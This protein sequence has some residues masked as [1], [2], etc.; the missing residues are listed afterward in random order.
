MSNA[1]FLIRE[2]ILEDMNEEVEQRCYAIT[3]NEKLGLTVNPHPIN[4]EDIVDCSGEVEDDF[5]SSLDDHQRLNS[6]LEHQGKVCRV[7]MEQETRKSFQQIIKEQIKL[8]SVSGP[9][10]ECSSPVRESNTAL[11]EDGVDQ[12]VQP[13]SV[14]V[15]TVECSSPDRVLSTALDKSIS[16]ENYG[17]FKAKVPMAKF[18]NAM[19]D[20]DS[21]EGGGFRCA[22][23]SKCLNCKTSSKRT[24]ISLREARE[25]QLIEESV[26]IDVINRRVTVNYP[27]LKNPVEF[28]TAV[29]SN[30]CNY[31]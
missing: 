29:H 24:A 1:V 28:L 31:S 7:H 2:R 15:N 16:E 20:E 4:E 17:E 18:R 6:I 8:G 27:F 22:E 19:D 26:K 21:E 3:T 11:G 23:C 13:G 14:V 5:E 10:G 12:D 25:Q 30:L 9:A